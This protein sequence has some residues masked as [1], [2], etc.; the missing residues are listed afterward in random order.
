MTRLPTAF[1]VAANTAILLALAEPAAVVALRLY[2]RL[3][4]PLSYGK[5]SAAQRSSYTHMSR[6]DV[7]EL[8]GAT[9]AIR[10]EYAHA[11]GLVVDAMTSRFVN[12]DERGLRAN[13]PEPPPANLNGAIWFLGGST[14]FG[15][16]IADPETIPAQLERLTGRTTIN[17]GVPAHTSVIENRLLGYRL[18]LGLRPSMAV[19]LDGINETCDPDRFD[20]DLDRLVANAQ[21]GYQW[22]LGGPVA[23]GASRVIRRARRALGHEVDPPDPLRLTCHDAGRSYPLSQLHARVLAERAALCRLYDVTCLTLVQPF[24]GL[25][26][27]HDDEAFLRSDNAAYFRELFPHLAPGWRDAGAIFITDA[28]DGLDRHAFV[29]SAHYN[30]EASRVLAERIAGLLPPR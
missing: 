21:E 17:M 1:V 2:D 20:E 24:A 26:G 30:A 23:F 15:F 29:D 8:L 6:T 27:R 14:T 28:L 4:P 25:H 22:H 13:G 9:G 18:R 19:F 16:G 12:V 5:L 3:A 10:Y 7:N 11:F